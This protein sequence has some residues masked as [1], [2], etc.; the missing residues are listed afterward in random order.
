M[1]LFMMARQA[2]GFLNSLLSVVWIKN[3]FKLNE[4]FSSSFM[5]TSQLRAHT[6][7]TFVEGLIRSRSLLN[8][9]SHFFHHIF[10][11]QCFSDVDATAWLRPS[12]MG[13]GAALLRACRNTFILYGMN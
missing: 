11:I 7:T 4:H 3:K 10:H 9:L 5:P 8:I 6:H 2:T 13:S 12:R 1:L